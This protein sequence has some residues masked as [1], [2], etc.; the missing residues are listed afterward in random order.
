MKTKVKAT[1]AAEAKVI[2]DRYI[3]WLSPKRCVNLIKKHEDKTISV[4]AFNQAYEIGAN[5]YYY[6]V[7]LRDFPSDVICRHLINGIYTYSK[8]LAKK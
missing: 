7:A 1:N 3:K 5:S 8:M 6:D 4:I 2:T